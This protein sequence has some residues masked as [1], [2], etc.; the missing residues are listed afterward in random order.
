MLVTIAHGLR[1]GERMNVLPALAAMMLADGRATLPDDEGAGAM[2][3]PAPAITP[4]GVVVSRDPVSRR[5]R[6]ARR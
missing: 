5:D 2:L 1:A 3:P 4:A 6:G